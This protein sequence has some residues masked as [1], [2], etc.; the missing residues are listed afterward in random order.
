MEG[1][2]VV[3]HPCADSEEDSSVTEDPIEDI[4][5]GTEVS[6]SQRSTNDNSSSDD[7]SSTDDECNG[8]SWYCGPNRRL[9]DTFF[10][11]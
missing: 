11:Q 7:Q 10:R 1:H 4:D 5:P 8:L 3:A 6:D 2:R 9:Y